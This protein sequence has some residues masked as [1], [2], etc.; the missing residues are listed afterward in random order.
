[1]IDHTCLYKQKLKQ[2]AVSQANL[3]LINNS[4]KFISFGKYSPSSNNQY[5]GYDLKNM[6]CIVHH[7]DKYYSDIYNQ[8]LLEY[9]NKESETYKYIQKKLTE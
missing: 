9:R 1:M 8:V 6:G 5:M 3:D 4:A 2:I 7:T